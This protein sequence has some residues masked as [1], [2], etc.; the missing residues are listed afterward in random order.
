LNKTE[1][2]GRPNSEWTRNIEA[3]CLLLFSGRYWPIMGPQQTLYL[4]G[5][6]LNP[7][8]QN[9]TIVVLELEKPGCRLE[10]NRSLLH[11]DLNLIKVQWYTLV[12]QLK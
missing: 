4:P 5:S 11:F 12:L 6:K 2:L 1:L 7:P 3:D 10:Q 8:C 9:N